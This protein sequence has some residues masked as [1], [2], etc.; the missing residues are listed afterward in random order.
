MFLR[1]DVVIHL[2]RGNSNEGVLEIKR[3]LLGLLQRPYVVEA[4]ARD[5]AG[6]MGVELPG[7][8]VSISANGS[9]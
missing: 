7:T 3:W 8:H 1:V 5:A 2:S 6:E 4:F 9:D